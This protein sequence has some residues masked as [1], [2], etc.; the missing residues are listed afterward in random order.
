MGCKASGASRIIV[1]DINSEKFTKAKAL[2]ATDCL[3]PKDL[4]K[5]IQEVIVEMTNG[6]VDFAFECV[7]GAKIMVCIF[8]IIRY[9]KYCLFAGVQP[10]LIQGIRSGDGVGDLFIYKYLSKI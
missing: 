9:N 8:F 4:D 6:G 2:G 7:G 1:V 10:R 5:P 3:N